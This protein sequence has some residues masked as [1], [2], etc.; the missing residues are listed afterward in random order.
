MPKKG[1]VDEM[2]ALSNV[3]AALAELMGHAAQIGLA[4]GAAE[5]GLMLRPAR[6]G[7]HA[8]L[9]EAVLRGLWAMDTG[10]V[11]PCTLCRPAPA[12]ALVLEYP[13]EHKR[14]P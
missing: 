4:N 2:L 1:V 3:L 9:N 10:P 6:G 14:I 8:E 5:G 12:P 7:A 13:P 11:R